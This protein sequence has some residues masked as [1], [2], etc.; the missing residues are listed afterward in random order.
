MLFF[1]TDMPELGPKNAT[2]FRLRRLGKSME[3][4]PTESAAALV[5]SL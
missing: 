3:L 1:P 2:V 5:Y 4:A